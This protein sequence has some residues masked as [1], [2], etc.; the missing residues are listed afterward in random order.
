MPKC[1][2][3]DPSLA[4]KRLLQTEGRRGPGGG[5]ARATSGR[6]ARDEDYPNRATNSADGT[7]KAPAS[8]RGNA[9]FRPPNRLPLNPALG[10]SPKGAKVCRVVRRVTES[11][12]L[13]I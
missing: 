13:N 6:A 3:L 10:R 9:D 8:S 11:G 1:T 5:V 7:C 4:V 2:C 12:G